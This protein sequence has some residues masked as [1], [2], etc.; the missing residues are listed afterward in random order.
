MNC[1]EVINTYLSCRTRQ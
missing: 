1:S